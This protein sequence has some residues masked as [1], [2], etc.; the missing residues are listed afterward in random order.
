MTPPILSLLRDGLDELR[1]DSGLAE[2]LGDYLALLEKWNRAYNLTAVRDIREMVPRH[3]LDSL[4]VLPY[5]HGNSLL[6]VGTGP[7]LPGL[8]VAL[9]RPDWRCVLLDSNQKK[10]RFVTQA[11]LELGM[12]NVEVVTG[13]IEQYRPAQEF[14]SVISRAY[15][16]LALFYRQTA[17]LRAPSGRLVAMKGR[18]LPEEL[19]AVRDVPLET[20]ALRVPGLE[21]ERHLV[22]FQMR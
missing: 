2:P 12:T 7:G 8:V 16:E 4:A 9:A 3:I 15:A 19:E 18:L 6:D 21:A 10:T 1:L 20:V 17:R 14:A 5:L 13:R 11:V 22:I